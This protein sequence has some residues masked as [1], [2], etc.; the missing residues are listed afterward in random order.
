[1]SWSRWGRDLLCRVAVDRRLRDAEVSHQ[2]TDRYPFSAARRR[3]TTVREIT[4]SAYVLNFS[5]TRCFWILPRA[6][7]GRV[8]TKWTVRGFL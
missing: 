5:T 1:M 3:V 4:V 2:C 8:S 6:L 7:R